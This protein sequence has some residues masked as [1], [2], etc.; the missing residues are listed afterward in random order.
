M[1]RS[2]YEQ[3]ATAQLLSYWERQDGF[4]EPMGCVATTYTL[5]P[6]LF[7][8]QCLARLVGLE[9]DPREGDAWAYVIEREERLSQISA[10]VLVDKDHVP[11]S[12]S[13]RWSVLPVTL[14]GGGVLHAKLSILAWRSRVRVLIGSANLTEPGYR[15]SYEQMACLDFGPGGSLPRNILDQAL[16]F[17]ERLAEL[18]PGS[19]S[20]G[21]RAGLAELLR[22]IRQQAKRWPRGAWKT[23]QPCATLLPVWPGEPSL[24]ARIS[25]DLWRGAPPSY[26]EVLSPFFDSHS[27]GALAT[28]RGL[29]SI[30]ARGRRTIRFD[31]PGRRR[32]DR[33]IEI[34]LPAAF[35]KPQRSG[36]EHQ[37]QIVEM[38]EVDGAARSL[39]AKAL[40]LMRGDRA[41]VVVGSSNFT[42]AGTAAA[43]AGSANVELNA[44]YWI[45]SARGPFGKIA[46]QAYP[47]LRWVDADGR[48]VHFLAGESQTP[49]ARRFD[50][51]PPAFGLALFR[52][53]G[54]GG[55]LTLDVASGVP[56]GF[57]VESEPGRRL[58]D[59]ASWRRAHRPAALAVPWPG[60]RP[61][62]AIYVRWPVPGRTATAVWPVNA[63]DGS[64]LPPP[65]ELRSL[66]LDELMEVLTSARPLHEALGLIMRR[67]SRLA[68][69]PQDGPARVNPHRKVDTSGFILQRMRRLGR[70]LEGL[71]SR[72]EQ[73]AHSVD[74]LRWRLQGPV[75]PLALAERLAQAPDAESYGAA[76]LIAEVAR[77]VKREV[78]WTAA[79]RALGAGPVRREVRATLDALR[80]QA[81]ACPAAGALSAYVREAL[82]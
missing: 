2:S 76:F 66:T 37:F 57:R 8:E 42:S 80:A 65:D 56:A 52:A 82:R 5:D 79:E 62:S 75:G 26:A 12:R 67:R 55:E 7:E 33:H 72:L 15:R 78:R 63:A 31:A 50:A 73:P 54:A 27:A 19:A 17:V 4:G 48:H 40:W 74:A 41:A 44:G 70:A 69:Q 3:R 61:P 39:H 9:S 58:L 34:D 6:G 18:S 36:D 60:P 10:H 28:L 68:G 53:R 49:E 23:R 71:R 21:P 32:P 25:R 24:F 16:A 81:R 22:Q 46:A 29:H 51:L 45:R 20:H 77:T 13:L 64:S 47:P 59:E 14:R 38:Q 1:S 11:T 35:R 30:M 43:R